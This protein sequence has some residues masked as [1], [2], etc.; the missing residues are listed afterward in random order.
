MKAAKAKVIRIMDSN[1]VSLYM[2]VKTNPSLAATEIFTQL[3]SQEL[4]TLERR[5]HGLAR[6]YI[7]IQQL[8]IRCSKLQTLQFVLMFEHPR[9]AITTLFVLKFIV[10]TVDNC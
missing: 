1:C 3:P 7:L 8:N 6:F 10:C 9:S 4:Q 5:H 2:Y